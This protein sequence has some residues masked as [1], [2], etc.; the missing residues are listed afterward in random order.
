MSVFIAQQVT[1]SHTIHL[2]ATPHEVFPLFSPLGEKHWVQGWDPEMLYPSSGVAQSGTVFTT[3]HA[4]E[5]TRIWTIIAYAREQ[6]HVSYLNVLP[7]SHV[8]RI[9]VSC[10]AQGT[11]A[12]LARITYTLTALTPQGNTYLDGFTQEYYQAY[13]SFWETAITHYLLHGH[14]HPHPEA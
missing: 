1:R 11:Q 6:A 12:T 13:I 7:D 5:P 10:E 3:Q 4:N 8:S 9:E 14:M 2:P